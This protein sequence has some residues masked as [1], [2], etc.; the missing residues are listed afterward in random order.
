[1]TTIDRRQALG[2]I[3]AVPMASLVIGREEAVAAAAQVAQTKPYAL[4]FFTPREYRL[5]PRTSS[6]DGTLHRN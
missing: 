6:D 2:M 1:M 3:G 5:R 4:R